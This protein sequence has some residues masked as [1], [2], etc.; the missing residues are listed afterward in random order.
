M[1]DPG[2][3]PLLGL[4]AEADPGGA[5]LCLVPGLE[6]GVHQQLLN[7]GPLGRVLLQAPLHR[8]KQLR[9]TT[10]DKGFFIKINIL[11]IKY[12]RIY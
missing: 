3:G 5:A 12:K 6:V 11:P 9:V 1:L 8:V 4:A 10:A 7:G 2:H